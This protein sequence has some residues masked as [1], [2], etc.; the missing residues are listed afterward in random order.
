MKEAFLVIVGTLALATNLFAGEYFGLGLGGMDIEQV[1][2]HFKKTGAR[3][4]DNYGYKGHSKKLL[5]MKVDY[6]EKFNKFGDVKEAWLSF[7]P[8]KKLYEVSVT[9]RDAGDTFKTIRDALDSKYGNP[10]TSGMGFNQDFIYRDKS[11]DINLNRNTFG[12][13]S[14]QSTT[15]I[16]VFTPA[17]AE[18]GKMKNLIDEDIRKKNAEKA[19]SDL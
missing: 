7:S 4:S 10:E 6:Y 19:A 9:W 18:V 1:K 13:G 11:V 17:L 14:E 3:F 5:V 8:D 2:E 12:F 16:Y 15:L